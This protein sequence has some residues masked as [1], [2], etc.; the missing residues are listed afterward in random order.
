MTSTTKDGGKGTTFI[1]ISISLCI[2]EGQPQELIDFAQQQM[3]PYELGRAYQFCFEC[4]IG[5]FLYAR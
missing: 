5:S 1:G 2:A 4:F 3:G